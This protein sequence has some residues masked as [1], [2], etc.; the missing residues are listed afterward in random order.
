MSVSGSTRVPL[1]SVPRDPGACVAWGGKGSQQCC[2]PANCAPWATRRH[3]GRSRAGAGARGGARWCWNG[4]C[5]LAAVQ[6]S[7]AQLAHPSPPH[8]W[9]ARVAVGP[10]TSCSSCA[11]RRRANI[12]LP[13]LTSWSA[14][15]EKQQHGRRRGLSRCCLVRAPNEQ[16]H[17][18]AFATSSVPLACACSHACACMP[19]RRPTPSPCTAGGPSAACTSR[20]TRTAPL[21]HLMRCGMGSTGTCGV[22][23]LLMRIPGNRGITKLGRCC[24]GSPTVVVSTAPLGAGSG[25]RARMAAAAS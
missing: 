5:A 2:Q 3:R 22:L 19:A 15:G 11:P 16:P 13:I 1:S 7:A 25:L 9:H 20:A 17:M 24:T 10:C 6:R 14:L 23:L 21:A 12:S 18:A 8:C 4:A